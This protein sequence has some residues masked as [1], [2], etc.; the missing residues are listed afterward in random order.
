MAKLIEPYDVKHED[1]PEPNAHV[2]SPMREIL[3][4]YFVASIVSMP[5]Y[6]QQFTDGMKKIM[7]EVGKEKRRI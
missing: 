2:A 5:E 3:N 7:G 6:E 4:A 1:A